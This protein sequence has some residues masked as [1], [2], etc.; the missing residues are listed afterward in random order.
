M[1]PQLLLLL[2]LLGPGSSLQ[3]LKAREDRSPEAPGLLLIRGRR[4]LPLSTEDSEEDYDS[5]TG[6]TNIPEDLENSSMTA[7][8]AHSV[9][10]VMGTS[11]QRGSIGP[12]TP[13]P[14]TLEVATGD[15]AGTSIMRNESGAATTQG[16]AV[17]PGSLTEDLTTA[18]PPRM[19][20]PSLAPTTVEALSWGPATTEALS[21]LPIATKASST[22]STSTEALSTAELALP[23]GSVAI[24]TLSTEPAAT[25]APAT[26]THPTE[27]ASPRSPSTVTDSKSSDSFLKWTNRWNLLLET[28]ATP[29][30]APT[31]AQDYIPVKQCLLAILI[32]ALV[33]TIFLVCTV[34]LAVRLSRK[35]HMYP[36]RSY[37]PTEMVCISS[38]LPDGGEAPAATTTA[39]GGLP[40]AK[41]Q[42][43]QAE[44]G[45][46]REGDDLTLHSFLP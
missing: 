26:E 17:T 6:G 1:I 39:N 32:L 10:A 28:T 33:A 44:P 23:T 27:L 22:E 21:T 24:E 4:Q 7:V 14:A 2:T 43:K 31:R 13:D 20:T 45:E 3:L 41:S 36:V 30:T 15:S 46:D 35:S 37:S 8:P 11:A 29:N 12:G 40:R 38:L 18:I 25:A 34:V 42:D 9:L 16:V 5:V 19:E